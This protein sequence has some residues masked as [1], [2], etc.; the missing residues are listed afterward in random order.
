[1]LSHPQDGYRSLPASPYLMDNARAMTTGCMEDAMQH[2]RM[3]LEGDYFAGTPRYAGS[4]LRS[5]SPYGNYDQD[6]LAVS[7]HDMGLQE[8]VRKSVGLFPLFKRYRLTNQP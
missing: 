2:V 3:G 7:M 5:R 4:S 1:M 6:S 8:I